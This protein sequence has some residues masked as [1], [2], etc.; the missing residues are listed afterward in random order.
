MR[1]FS[2]AFTLVELLV[3]VAILG[4]LCAI[5][6]PVFIA[7]KGTAN[8]AVCISNLHQLTAGTEL[9]SED[10]DD[11]FML[12]NHQPASNAN[13]RNDRTWVQLV[14][15]YVHSFAIFHCPSDQAGRP[16]PEAT[17]DQDLVPGDTYSQYYTASLHTDY[18]YNYQNLAPIVGSFDTRGTSTGEAL[19]SSK[20]K[21][22]GEVRAPS[23]TLLFVDSVWSRN[24]DGNPVGGG[25]WLV[26][27]PCRFY[28]SHV[29]SF[30]GGFGNQVPVFTTSVGWSLEQSAPEVYGNAWPWHGN[31]M[32][33]AFVDGS[34]RSLTPQSLEAGCTVAPSWQGT[35]GDSNAYLWDTR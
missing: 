21:A 23:S 19:W 20:P 5:L 30:T 15:P 1:R 16:K 22:Y 29:D 33:V 13:S 7:V 17:F 12:V 6:F 9:Y 35:I 31:H 8:R 11:R 32:N 2:L 18:G 25:N 10:Y 24:A 3:V 26:V 14:L 28:A 4:V 27:P 34:V